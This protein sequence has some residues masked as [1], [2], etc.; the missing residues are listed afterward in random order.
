M[1]RNRQVLE[2]IV[3]SEARTRKINP[4]HR[5]KHEGYFSVINYPAFFSYNEI[6]YS[7]LTLLPLHR[8]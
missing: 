1:M 7:L 8:V 5:L 3:V 2:R 4:S 6:L